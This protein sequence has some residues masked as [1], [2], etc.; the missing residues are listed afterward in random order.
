MVILFFSTIRW[1]DDLGYDP[2]DCIQRAIQCQQEFNML[3]C[4][5]DIKEVV[6]SREVFE[7]EIALCKKLSSEKGGGCG[8]GKCTD[9]GVIAL[10]HKLHKGVLLEGEELQ[11]I[12]DEA[13]N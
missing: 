4:S 13:L 2:K 3:S 11:R 5:T 12:K 7:R 1:C 6:I 9:C 8:W 10:L